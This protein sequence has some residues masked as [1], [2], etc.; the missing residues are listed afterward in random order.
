MPLDPVALASWA[1]AVTVGRLVL[2]PLMFLVIPEHDRGA[3]G[4]FA[5]WFALSASDGIDG[6]I[7]RRRG[8]TRSGAFL[9]P[10]ADKVLVLGAMFTL[11]RYDV[12]PLL[13]VAVIAAREFVVSVYRTFVGSKGISV[14]ASRLAKYKTLSQQLAVGFALLPWSARD[15]TWLWLACLWL[16]VLLAVVS[17]AQYLGRAWGSR[18]GHGPTGP[19]GWEETVHA[20]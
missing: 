20:V 10:L 18:G 1:N 12:F 9:D 5:L 6:V 8:P 15:A 2:S 7:A 17:A 11:V 4:A 14:P 19:A 16:A 3:W 13:P